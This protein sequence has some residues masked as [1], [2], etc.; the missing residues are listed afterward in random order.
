MRLKPLWVFFSAA[1]HSTIWP[2][3]AL[4]WGWLQLT[5]AVLPS[6][7]AVTLFLVKY[8]HNVKFF[9]VVVFVFV[10]P[11][12]KDKTLH[13]FSEAEF[14]A[15]RD[16]NHVCHKSSLATS[17]TF[18][19]VLQLCFSLGIKGHILALRWHWT[20]S[21]SK[22]NVTLSQGNENIC[23]QV[24]FKEEVPCIN[25]RAAIIPT[26]ISLIKAI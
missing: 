21:A 2:Q 23:Q 11:S 7:K 18:T 3:I 19:A 8:K 17:Q 15:L 1:W 10:F 4:G 20:D 24:T 6:D 26:L 9:V 16:Q 13:S 12:K 5:H 22:K 25:P 14:K